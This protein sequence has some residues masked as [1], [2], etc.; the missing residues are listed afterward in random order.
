MYFREAFSIT[1]QMSAL[2]WDSKLDRS[3][4]ATLLQGQPISETG[5]DLLSKLFER[6]CE[7]HLELESLEEVGDFNLRSTWS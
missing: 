7:S 4:S 5:R 6:K 3:I 2:S 1:L